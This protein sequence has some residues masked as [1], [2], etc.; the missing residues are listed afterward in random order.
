MQNDRFS[1]HVHKLIYP[2]L[3]KMVPGRKLRARAAQRHQFCCKW[4]RVGPMH[5]HQ[6]FCV[7][8][9]KWTCPLVKL[10]CHLVSWEYV[11]EDIRYD[12]E[13]KKR[14]N[15]GVRY[16]VE[17][18]PDQNMFTNRPYMTISVPLISHWSQFSNGTKIIK[19]REALT[20]F[21]V[22]LWSDQ[23]GIKIRRVHG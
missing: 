2:F 7:F 13:R 1:K 10:S 15:S 21:R 20:P 17:W 18:R 12:V 16:G 8:S 14:Y 6:N 19:I 3:T 11:S 9:K 5:C 4:A 23:G 22:I